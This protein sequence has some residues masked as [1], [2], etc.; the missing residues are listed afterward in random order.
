[1]DGSSG[2]S[3]VGFSSILDL[4]LKYRLVDDVH[5]VD[6]RL[7]SRPWD[8]HPVLKEIFGTYTSVP[9]SEGEFI[10]VFLNIDSH[11]QSPPFVDTG[12][13]ENVVEF[14]EFFLG[15][16]KGSSEVPFLSE[17]RRGVTL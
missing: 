1:M 3:I 11:D 16:V 4:R 17:R 8:R 6:E 13:W 9:I 12:H 10:G 14:A 15:S 7:K 2:E 5:E